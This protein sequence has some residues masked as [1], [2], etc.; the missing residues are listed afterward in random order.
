MYCTVCIWTKINIRTRIHIYKY[1]YIYMYRYL[2]YIMYGEYSQDPGTAPGRHSTSGPGALPWLPCSKTDKT[3]NITKNTMKILI[4][5]KTAGTA[6]NPAANKHPPITSKL[7]AVV[8][9]HVF[10]I[11]RRVIRPLGLLFC[12]LDIF[13]YL[14]TLGQIFGPPTPTLT[15]GRFLSKLN[16]FLHG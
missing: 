3:T 6:E 10:T 7:L 4:T 16:G 14:L 11:H 13:S 15:L 12:H 2:L 8:I 5:R 9:L 1:I